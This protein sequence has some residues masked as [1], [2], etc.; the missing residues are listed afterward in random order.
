MKN[1]R[2][3]LKVTK[4]QAEEIRKGLRDAYLTLR[5]EHDAVN[6]KQF[7]IAY[8]NVIE[9]VVPDACWWE[10]TDVEIFSDLFFNKLP[11]HTILKIVNS[12]EVE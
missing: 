6:I 9:S 3:L 4:V 5:R 10:I 7:E 8:Q 11:G 12:L 2:P 1:K